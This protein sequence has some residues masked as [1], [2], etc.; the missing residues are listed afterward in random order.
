MFVF[1]KH[2]AGMNE[3]R[4]QAEERTWKHLI[5]SSVRFCRVLLLWLGPAPY[6]TDSQSMRAAILVHLAGFLNNRKHV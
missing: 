1:Q 5:L 6:N 4:A 2:G 3:E